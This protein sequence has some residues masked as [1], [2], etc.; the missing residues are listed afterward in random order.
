MR[1]WHPLWDKLK[2]KANYYFLPQKEAPIVES[3]NFFL[4]V[5]WAK[6][7]S[8]QPTS[9]NVNSLAFRQITAKICCYFVSS[10]FPDNLYLYI[11][12]GMLKYNKY[13]ALNGLYKCPGQS[14]DTKDFNVHVNLEIIEVFCI[15]EFTFLIWINVA[16]ICSKFDIQ[17]VVMFTCLK[18][19]SNWLWLVILWLL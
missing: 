1:K 2:P 5:W 12:R 13:T 8:Y 16:F 4:S 11:G 19:Q 10:Y 17:S 7:A 14:G 3:P 9:F 6:N 15:F 18:L